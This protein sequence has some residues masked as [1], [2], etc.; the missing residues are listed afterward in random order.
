MRSASPDRL[1]GIARRRRRSTLAAVATLLLLAQGLMFRSALASQEPAPTNRDQIFFEAVGSQPVEQVAAL[2]REGAV[3]LEFRG[4]RDV[5]PLDRAIRENPD[6]RVVV[7][8]LDHGAD[9]NW[10]DGYGSTPLLFAVHQLFSHQTDEWTSTVVEALLMHGARVNQPAEGVNRRTPLFVVS[11]APIVKLLLEHGADPNLRD[12]YG[13]FALSANTGL[14]CYR[15]DALRL[16]VEHGADLQLAMSGYPSVLAACAYQ[17]QKPAIETLL[18]MGISINARGEGGHT[19]LGY[20]VGKSTTMPDFVEYLLSL[21]AD[22]NVQADNGF[23]PLLAAAETNQ[24]A[25]VDLLLAHGADPCLRFRP[26]E[27][28]G[29]RGGAL[30]AIQWTKIRIDDHFIAGRPPASQCRILR[31]L[32][33]KGAGRCSNWLGALSDRRCEPP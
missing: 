28:E 32:R 5:T 9:P 31:A 12:H 2:Y 22:P 4:K 1:Q 30:D 8:L 17:Y 15:P 20:V 11:R 16:M 14:F 7:F 19:A 33:A 25:V 6:A 23:V 13:A 29:Y 18:Q 3:N 10:Q 26:P 27:D 24:E 21:G